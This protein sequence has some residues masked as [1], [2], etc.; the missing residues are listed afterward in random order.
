MLHL[1]SHTAF[2]NHK[3]REHSKFTKPIILKQQLLTKQKQAEGQDSEG[4][5][6]NDIMQFWCCDMRCSWNKDQENNRDF[7]NPTVAISAQEVLKHRCFLNIEATVER[8][9]SDC[10][11]QL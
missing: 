2:T 6:Q 9:R 3:L 10:R 7:A 1:F 4:F 11:K 5:H 8:Q